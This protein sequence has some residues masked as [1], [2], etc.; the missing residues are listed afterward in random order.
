M[1]LMY[2]VLKIKSSG[3]ENFSLHGLIVV[4]QVKIESSRRG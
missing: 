3:V 2:V 4:F 1:V